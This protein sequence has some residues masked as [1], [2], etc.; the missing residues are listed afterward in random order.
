M[1][2]WHGVRGTPCRRLRRGADGNLHR[3]L[4]I[5]DAFLRGPR[6]AD[7]RRRKRP[8]AGGERMCGT[9][10]VHR[11]GEP[12]RR[13][14]SRLAGGRRRYIACIGTHR[15]LARLAGARPHRRSAAGKRLLGRPDRACKQAA[16]RRCP[17]RKSPIAVARLHCPGL[18]RIARGNPLHPCSKTHP[19]TRQTG[20]GIAWHTTGCHERDQ[21]E[22]RVRAIRLPAAPRH[23]CRGAAADRP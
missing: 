17:T 11:L 7:V 3:P 12:A 18:E 8:P 9:G 2:A 5:G 20:G 10:P 13:A 4:S 1:V 22:A 15:Q 21:L 16:L 23:S 14:K 6:I 19:G